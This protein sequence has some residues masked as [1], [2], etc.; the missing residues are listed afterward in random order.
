MSDKQKAE[1]PPAPVAK[2]GSL[3]GDLAADTDDVA[4]LRQRLERARERLA[5]YE[6]FDRI[7]QENIRRSSELMIEATG[8]REQAD[9]ALAE[10]ARAQAAQRDQQNRE[11]AH[12]AALLGDLQTELERTRVSLDAIGARVTA[13][14]GS[15]GDQAPG[16]PADAPTVVNETAPTSVQDNTLLATTVGSAG[17]VPD[18]QPTRG[19]AE[20]PAVSTPSPSPATATAQPLEPAP[21]N[22]ATSDTVVDASATSQ[23]LATAEPHLV[24]VL[25]HGVPTARVAISLQNHLRGLDQVSNVEAREFV[26]GLLRLQVTSAGAIDAASLNGWGDGEGAEVIRALPDL[27]EVTLPGVTE[28]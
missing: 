24:D 10:Q 16:Q 12:Y 26:E 18:I 28:R 6:S 21:A 13:A 15:L 27:L 22:P 11:R 8:L 2:P 20:Q 1:R 4:T 19:A 9:R 3:T 17:N 23:A 14:L 5:F 25:V 7:I